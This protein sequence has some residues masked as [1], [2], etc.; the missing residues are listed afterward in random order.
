MSR[1]EIIPGETPPPLK[2]GELRKLAEAASFALQQEGRERGRLTILI[3]GDEEIAR[4]NA[5]F[6]GVNEPTDVLAFYTGGEDG[7]VTAPGARDY[8]GDV[9]ISWQRAE[10][11]A[12]ELGHSLMEELITLVIHGVLHLLGYRDDEESEKAKMWA[13]Q[14]ELKALFMEGKP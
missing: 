5:R 7:F 6:K 13:R 9:V 1:V 2:R 3:T 11:Q 10:E 14:E 8:L 12:G 4:L